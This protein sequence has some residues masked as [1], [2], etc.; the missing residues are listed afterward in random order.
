MH[1][2]ILSEISFRL[3]VFIYVI[4]KFFYLYLV[5]IPKSIPESENKNVKCKTPIC[6]VSSVWH[7]PVLGGL[8]SPWGVLPS[9][10]WISWCALIT[11]QHRKHIVGAA[12]HLFLCSFLPFWC[13]GDNKEKNLWWNWLR[14][15][16]A[17][18]I[19]KCLVDKSGPI[20][21]CVGFL[22][23]SVTFIWLF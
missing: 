7:S 19:L 18:W 12:R 10:Q 14:R 9:S 1:T 3:C 22:F 8:L 20:F 15:A 17:W 4:Y 13:E 5:L 23:S 6:D 2:Q 11:Q 16:C 21:S